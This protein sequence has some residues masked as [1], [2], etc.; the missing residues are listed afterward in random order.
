MAYNGNRK[1]VFGVN[2]GAYK[3]Q[4]KSWSS[5]TSTT[6]VQLYHVTTSTKK[7]MCSNGMW[8][9]YHKWISVRGWAPELFFVTHVLI[10]FCCCFCPFQPDSLQHCWLT[11]RVHNTI[12]LQSTGDMCWQLLTASSHPLPPS[13]CHSSIQ[14]P[15]GASF[16]F[17]SEITI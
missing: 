6:T 14:P 11:K 1:L 2:G 12:C 13:T 3:I 8:Y 5:Y 4:F 9:G 15:K 10:S 16:I 7:E 17:W